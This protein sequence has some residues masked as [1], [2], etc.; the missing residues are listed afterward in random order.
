MA[1]GDYQETEKELTG[2]EKHTQTVK[3]LQALQRLQAQSRLRVNAERTKR[4]QERYKLV[5]YYISMNVKCTLSVY[6][7]DDV[8]CCGALGLL[9]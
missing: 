3:S 1:Y 9:S 6:S 2:A 7:I 8:L 5:H 4:V